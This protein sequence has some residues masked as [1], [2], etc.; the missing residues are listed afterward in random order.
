VTLRDRILLAGGVAAAFLVG[1]AAWLFISASA[2]ATPP[3]GGIRGALESASSRTPAPSR[4]TEGELVV[5]IEGGVAHPG[6]AR[7]P[8]GSRVADAIA[9]AGGYADSADLAAA[10]RTLNLASEL[11]DGAQVYVPRLG[12]VAG[13]GTGTG[14]GGGSGGGGGLVDLNHATESELDALPGIGP[15]TVGKIVAAREEQPFQTLDE[16]VDRKVMTSSQLDKIRD[17]ATV[18]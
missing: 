13:G 11:T 17:L 1:A 15:V 14:S 4:T 6:V 8:P 12:D 3:D 16:L 7:L 10:A 18:G 5:D 9:A 2:S